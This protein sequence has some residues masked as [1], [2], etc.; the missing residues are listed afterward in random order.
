MVGNQWIMTAIPAQPN[1]PSSKTQGKTP[2]F[3]D[4]SIGI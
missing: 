4:K 2:Q 3:A 1:F